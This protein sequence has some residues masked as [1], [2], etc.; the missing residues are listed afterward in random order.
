M[1]MRQLSFQPI[2]SRM[3]QWVKLDK[4]RQTTRYLSRFCGRMGTHQLQASEQ[5][6]A[7]MTTAHAT[8]LK[9]YRSFLDLAITQ[10]MFLVDR[11]F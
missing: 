2:T 7:H 6:F 5:L 9:L 8:C 10:A 1:L 4:Y 11:I 3:L